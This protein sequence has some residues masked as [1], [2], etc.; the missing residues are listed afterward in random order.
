[1]TAPSTQP[2]EVDDASTVSSAQTGGERRLERGS[3]DGVGLFVHRSNRL[4]RLAAELVDQMRAT[5]P[6][7]VHA[8]YTVAIGSRGMERWLRHRIAQSLG[9]CANVDFCFPSLAVSRSAAVLLGD[10]PEAESAWTPDALVWAVLALLPQLL[11]DPA[12]EPVQ[13]YVASG[14]VPVDRRTYGLAREMADLVDRYVHYRRDWLDDWRRDQQPEALRGEPSEPWQRLLFR[15]L[16]ARLGATHAAAKSSS[17]EAI[18]DGAR[19]RGLEPAPLHVFGVSSMPPAY[20]ETLARLARATRIDLYLL[21]PSDLYWGDLRTVAQARRDLRLAPRDA[22]AQTLREAM[23]RQNPLL[24]SFGRLSRD[25]QV[26]LEELPQGYREGSTSLFVDPCAET[27]TPT[28]LRRVQSDVLCLASPVE[29]RE[30]VAFLARRPSLADDSIQVHACHGPTR[31]VEVLRE[32]L[33]GLFD[34]HPDLAPRDVVVMTPDV[35]TYAPLVA[36]IFGEGRARPGDALDDAGRWGPVGAPRIPVAS[37]DLGLREQNPLADVLLRVLELAER[38]VTASAVLELVGLGPVRRRFE[39]TTAEL[40]TLHGWVASSGIRWGIDEQ[41]RARFDQPEDRAF[42]FRFGLER[43]ALGVT[44][45]DDD[46]LFGQVAPFDELEGGSAALYGRFSAY[47][48]ALFHAV[49]SL[50]AP[51]PLLAY[52]TELRAMLDALT[53]PSAQATWLREQIDDEL[54][55]LDQQAN[56]TGF[57][58]EIELGALRAALAGRFDGPRAGDRPITGAVSVCALSPMRSVPFRVVCLLGMDD[59]VFPRPSHA[60]GFD[61]TRVAPRLGDRDGRDEDRHLILEAVLSARDNLIVL[62]TGREPH[63]NAELPPAV[64]VAELL[65]YLDTAFP[66]PEGLKRTRDLVVTSHGLQPFS[67]ASFL[68][69]VSRAP[70]GQ[71]PRPRSFDRRMLEAARVAARPRQEVP[72][73]FREGPLPDAGLTSLALDDLAAFI[74]NPVKFLL[75]RRLGLFLAPLVV[76]IADRESIETDSLERWSLADDLLQ[77][78]LQARTRPHL[79]APH[80]FDLARALFTARAKLPFGAA[81]RMAFAKAKTSVEAALGAG[82]AALARPR[83]TLDLDATVAGVRLTGPIGKVDAEGELLELTSDD[84]TKPK[85]LLRAWVRLLAL[86]AAE[87]AEPHQVR[88]VGVRAG[89]SGPTPRVY[90]LRPPAD[91]AERLR[92]LVDLHREGMRRPLLLFEKCSRELTIVGTGRRSPLDRAIDVWTGNNEVAGEGTEPHLRAVF[93]AEPPFLAADRR[94]PD[95]ELTRLANELWGPI[96]AATTEEA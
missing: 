35:A 14:A 11:A 9:I 15:S 79:S 27:Q 55:A 26:I 25:V 31:Q 42:T 38:R 16:E 52:T 66:P 7:D 13:R 19:A 46:D 90:V 72:A 33:L 62:F 63:T 77:W 45:S 96:D 54:G 71:P 92:E 74:R 18:L 20:L 28:M 82:G 53:S 61:L 32:A 75:N 59:G 88:M 24:T 50:R 34:D 68:P 85:H 57:E 41:D 76:Q 17:L 70:L 81:G 86:C 10:D 21:G 95:A 37:A 84:P 43:L 6:R 49:S 67:P 5:R 1:M 56:T 8:R 78:A 91:A 64:P 23:A 22:S 44:M 39:L 30:S 83:R 29:L 94:E 12:F 60:V 89:A 47:C 4:E 69:G 58:G 80:S 87:P 48:A 93:G 3:V 2:T 36:A 51:R 40:D 65:D 73:L